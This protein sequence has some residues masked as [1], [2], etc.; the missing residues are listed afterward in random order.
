MTAEESVRNDL[1][2]CYRLIEHAGMDDT[3]YTHISARVPGEPDAILINPFGLLFDEIQA[4][5]LIKVDLD[6]N[7]LSDSAYPIN[8]AGFVIHAA[9]YASRPDIGCLIHAHTVAGTAVSALQCGLLPVSQPAMEFFERVAYHDYEGLATDF[10]ES[11]RIVEGLGSLNVMMMRNHGTLVAGATIQAAFE[12]AYYLEQAC[13][14][15]LAAMATG[16]LLHIPSPAV[17]RKTADEYLIEGT[18]AK[19]MRLWRAMLKKVAHGSDVEK[20]NAGGR[21]SNRG[22]PERVSA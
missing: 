1:A 14:I 2:A 12:S 4:V 21:C 11:D 7:Q 15:Q 3:I 19:G 10:D 17:C 16:A 22:W 18:A 5:D 20:C 6:G 8:A 13:R 9:L